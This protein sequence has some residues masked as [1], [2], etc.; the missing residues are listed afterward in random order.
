VEA[1]VLAEGIVTAVLTEE[2]ATPIEEIGPGILMVSSLL[3]V[4]SSSSYSI[5]I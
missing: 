3:K 5:G 1:V 2:I 4:R